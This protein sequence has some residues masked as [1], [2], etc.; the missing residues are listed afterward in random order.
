LRTAISQ[1]QLLEPKSLKEAVALMREE[2]P[3][4]PLAGCTDVYVNLNFGTLPATRY[5]NLWNLDELRQIRLRGKTLSIGALATYSQLIRSPLVRRRLPILAAAAREIGGVQ[6]Q[7]RGTI[8]GNIANASPAGDALPVLAV[9]EATLVL[10]SASGRRRVAFNDFYTG[11]R[12]TV[13]APDELLVAV[14]ILPLSGRQW[15]RKVGTRAAQAI[16]KIVIAAIRDRRPRVALGSV[17]PTVLRLPQTEALLADGRPI[18]EARAALLEE[19]H[20]IDDMRSTADYRR[21]VAA[22]L[23]EQFWRETA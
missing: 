4:T 13:R 7:N 3:L 19:I 20:P 21:R 12:E 17:A 14:E 9:A 15:F 2:A 5:L 16:S 10:Q 6:I 22:N 11:Y 1:L 8:G 18:A 23:L